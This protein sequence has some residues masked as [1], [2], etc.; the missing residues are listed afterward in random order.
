MFPFL[1]AFVLNHYQTI[2][3]MNRNLM[4]VYALLMQILRGKEKIS[5]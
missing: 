5:L 3:K 2:P 4:C 1:I